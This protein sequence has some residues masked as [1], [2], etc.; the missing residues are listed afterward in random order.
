[1]PLAAWACTPIS[2]R[3]DLLH[4]RR[5][6]RRR[7]RSACTPRFGPAFHADASLTPLTTSAEA[8]ADMA[9]RA[10]TGL[11]THLW[12]ARALPSSTAKRAYQ[13]S[14]LA[15]LRSASPCGLVTLR[16]SDVTTSLRLLTRA[17]PRRHFTRYF[18]D[19]RL[20]KLE[21]AANEVREKPAQDARLIMKI[22]HICDAC[23]ARARATARLRATPV[24]S[25]SSSES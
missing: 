9:L 21:M 25:T 8:L 12:A 19:K 17:A 10:L 24:C 4:S 18:I 14:A 23:V 2:V 13:I 1:M 3:M 16:S 5:S 22:S 6:S 15:P 20:K 7:E 11:R